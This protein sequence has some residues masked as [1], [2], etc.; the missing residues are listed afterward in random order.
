MK[1]IIVTEQPKQWNGLNDIVTIVT[2]TDY[3]I[4]E[5]LANE[6]QIRIINLC[7]SYR[8]QSLGYYVSLLAEARGHK[9]FP[10]V[11]TMQDFNA[12]TSSAIV[13]I[14]LHDEIQQALKSIKSDEFTLSVY[15]GKNLAKH[16]DILC[17]KLH[18]L[19]PAPI[20]RVF[21]KYKKEWRVQKITPLAFSDVPEAHYPFITEVA[22]DYLARKRFNL[23]RKKNTF[24]DLAILYN[25]KE[26]IPPSNTIALK[27][28]IAA[29]NN[30]GLNVDLIEKDDYKTL[31]EYDALFIRETTSVNH[32]TYRF[33]R[34]AAAENLVVID[35]PVSILKCANKV[36]LAELLRKHRI[37]TPQTVILSKLNWKEKKNELIFPCVLK[38]PDSAFSQGVI[39][40][41]NIEEFIEA[42]KEFLNS[43][44]LIIAQ[45][46]MPTDFDWRIGLIDN[47]PLY[48]C[49]YYMARNHWQI[50]NWQSES[51]KEC[52]GD[53]D[54]IPIEKVPEG[55]IHTALKASKLIGNGLY[56]VDLKEVNNHIYV[57]EVNDNPSIDHGVEDQLLGDKLYE[58]IMQV[59]LQRIKKRHGYE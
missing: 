51:E 12:R 42:A 40:V 59:F 50:Y 1:P 20:F 48:A 44:E 16:Y 5:E 7:Q 9:V 32:Y 15:F 31:N 43:S 19:F 27:K 36:Y 49:R 28:F 46:F 55:I 39:K 13:E 26:I 30:L 45:T 35:D 38:Q 37:A 52:E 3:L 34:R 56:G 33:S 25:P 47:R 54:T 57:I 8:Y 14:E 22:K 10:S 4:N 24:H 53:A 18:G 17:R 6:R 41:N 21:F 2:A 58:Q 23:T 29:G 11:L